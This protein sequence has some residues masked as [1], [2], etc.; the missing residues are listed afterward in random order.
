MEKK[1]G[2]FLFTKF[3]IK[4]MEK[5]KMIIERYMVNRGR[6]T[7]KTPFKKGFFHPEKFIHNHKNFFCL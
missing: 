3:F 4:T 2:I 5:L 1:N 7:T 6:G